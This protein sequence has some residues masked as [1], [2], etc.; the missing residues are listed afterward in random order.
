MFAKAYFARRY[1]APVYWPPFLEF[2]PPIVEE[3]T[4]FVYRGRRRLK[5]KKRSF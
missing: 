5:A 3:I 2:I 1:F 4:K